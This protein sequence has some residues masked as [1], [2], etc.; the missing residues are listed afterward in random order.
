MEKQNTRKKCICVNHARL[1]NLK[2]IDVEIPHNSITVITGVSGSGKSTIAFDTIYAEGQRRFVESLSSYARQFLERMAKP[3]VDSI[4]GLPPAVAIEQQPFSK[5]PR[6]TVGT[7]TEVYDFIRLLYGRIGKTICYGCHQEVHKDSP[8]SAVKEMMKWNEKDKLYI[9]FP[10]SAQA[11][12]IGEELDRFRKLGFFRAVIDDTDELYDFQDNE[13]PKMVDRET[14]FILADRMVLR[15]DKETL[16]R[17]TDS[18]ETAF[19]AGDGKIIVRNI[20]QKEQMRFSTVFECADCG[21]VYVEPEPR[22]FSFNNPFGACPHCS[23]FGRTVGIDEELVIPNRTKSLKQ[24]AIHPFRGEGFSKHNREMLREAV[25]KGID[26]D[27]P[28]EEFTEDEWNFLWEGAGE[29]FGING[30]FQ[31]LEEKS[32]KLHYRVMTS[33]YRGYTTCK[34]CNG[35]RLRTSARQTFVGGKNIPELI[36]IPLSDVLAFFKNIKLSEHD[37]KIAGQLVSEIVWRTELLVEI[38]L[39]Y[40]TLDRLSHTLSG[41]ESQ[42]I[43]LTTA[44]GSSLVGTLYVM[45]EPSIGMHPRDTQRLLNIL[46]KLK[47]LG[48]TIIVVEHDPDIIKKADK[49]IDLGP[50]AGS[51]GG[52]V[53][54][55]GNLDELYNSEKSLTGLYLSGK[56]NIDISARKTPPLKR[57]LEIEKPRKHNLKMN[58]VRFPLNCM[59][60]VTGVSGS[61]KSTLIHD[62]LFRELKRFEGDYRTAAESMNTIKG[63]ENID[64]IEMVDQSPIGKSSRSTPATYTKAFDAIRELFASSQQARQMGFKPGYFSFNVPGGRCDVCEGEGAVTVDMQFL[65]D[66]HLECESCKGTRYKREAREITYK[67]KS[68]VDVLNMTIDEAMEFFEG[69]KKIT[70]KLKILQD[71]GLGYLTLGQPS[72]MLSGGEAQRIKLAS[73]L[74]SS[75]RNKGL[76]IFDEPTTGLHLDDI[77]RLLTCFRQLV[78]SG[79]SVIIIEHNIHIIASAD[80]IIDLGPEAGEAGGKVVAEG[81]PESIMKEK[82][83]YT[84]KALKDFYEEYK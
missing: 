1:H 3:D 53:V 38:G 55:Q 52:E 41:G 15:K 61:G 23:G 30:F 12:F 33:R 74:D 70:N 67:D 40:L 49:V 80:W 18:I 50:K 14:T 8:E 64:F 20:T 35:S 43:N 44:L 32:Y 76:F 75:N 17:L 65:P 51:F 26:T 29:F 54:F 11:R 45:D 59:I 72:N 4:V 57:Y 84:G 71:V 6:S 73:H 28:L 10:I 34:A 47:K 78:Q 31:M 39:E 82:T 69:N 27:K 46:F 19:H 81:S 56:K 2:D 5:N 13:L 58:S 9:L 36:K 79:H 16:T 21:I 37:K 83:S 22:L 48:N 25:K 63:A 68:I 77:S 7:T 62:V 24:N 60:V 42:R 66:V